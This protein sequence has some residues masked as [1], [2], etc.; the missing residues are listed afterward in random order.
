VSVPVEMEVLGGRQ[1]LEMLDELAGVYGPV[2]AEPPYDSAPKFS[3]DRFLDRTRGQAT[4]PGF[5]L[6][7]ARDGGRLVGFAFGFTMSAG[8]WWA[9]ASTPLGEVLRERKFAVIELILDRE[10]RG[11]GAGGKLMDAL[12][13]DRQ[14]RYATL[15]AVAD[16]PAYD[17]Y[18][19][20]GWWKAAEFR[21][22]RPYSDALVL[23]LHRDR[24]G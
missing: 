10:H 16:A 15:S 3:R 13:A 4:S 5:R 6:V 7:T 19:H 9:N 17:W 21:L 20:R 12:L 11:C 18:L 14:E 1:A 24:G 22:E 23:D 8:S 2:Y